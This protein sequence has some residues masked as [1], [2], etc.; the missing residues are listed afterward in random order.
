MVAEE[1]EKV[2]AKTSEV[3]RTTLYL[4][5]QPQLEGGRGVW[6]DVRAGEGRKK[7]ETLS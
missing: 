2:E 5:I 1:I 4:K 6:I 3:L 7:R